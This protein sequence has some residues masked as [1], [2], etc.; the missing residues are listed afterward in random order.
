[1]MVDASA[2]VAILNRE[3]DGPELARQIESAKAPFTSPLAVYETLAALMRE[4][5]WTASEAEAV[6][7]AFLDAAAIRVV[8]LTDGMATKAAVAFERFGK[9]RHPAGLNL[10]DCF[11]YACARAYRA[12]LLYKGNDF[13]RTDVNDRI[14]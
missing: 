14:F 4:N 2:M 9:G 1:M 13:E 8:P 3:P 5:R 7:R 10:G 6:V 12:T 11:A